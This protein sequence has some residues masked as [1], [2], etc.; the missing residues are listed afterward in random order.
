[1]ATEISRI[2]QKIVLPSYELSQFLRKAVFDEETFSLFMENSAK[3]LANNGVELDT[4]VAEDALMRLQSLV[5]RA[6]KFVV[7]EKIDSAKF[8]NVFGISVADVADAA[9]WTKIGKDTGTDTGTSTYPDP[10]TEPSPHYTNDDTKFVAG[11]EV[12]RPDDR[13]IRT[14]LLDALTLGTVI[15]GL[16]S[17]LKA[18]EKF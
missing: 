17:Q 18:L 11:K 14:P 10:S 1:M 15:A 12:L 8:E 5:A 7:K 4:S 16:D 2:T 9:A 3:T 13:F 6:H